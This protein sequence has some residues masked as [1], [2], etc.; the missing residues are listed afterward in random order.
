MWTCFLTPAI[1][2]RSYSLDDG[3]LARHAPTLF[4][5]RVRDFFD[6]VWPALADPR[7][8]D[9]REAAAAALGAALE[10]VAARPTAGGGAE[11]RS[12]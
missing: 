12:L 3:E 1:S 4:H 6:R 7:E 8:P 5:G 2:R 9:V 10:I 11:T